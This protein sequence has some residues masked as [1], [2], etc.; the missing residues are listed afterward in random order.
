MYLG[1]PGTVNTRVG[2]KVLATLLS[3]DDG[4]FKNCQFCGHEQSSVKNVD[5]HRDSVD[6]NTMFTRLEQHSSSSSLL[7]YPPQ[8]RTYTP[9][10]LQAKCPWVRCL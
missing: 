2:Q 8:S 7:I 5:F 4:E 6:T 3:H 1:K 10:N 9:R